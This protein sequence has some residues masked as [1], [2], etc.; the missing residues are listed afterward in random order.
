MHTRFSY[1]SGF[2]HRTKKVCVFIFFD[3]RTFVADRD[4]F[5]PALSGLFI[6]KGTALSSVPSSSGL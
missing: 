6:K 5:I 1:L 2:E 3:M 4:F